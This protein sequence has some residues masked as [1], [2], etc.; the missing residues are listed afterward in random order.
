MMVLIILA[1]L[2]DSE[3]SV[4]TPRPPR[5]DDRP[6]AEAL[7]ALI[8]E[9]RRRAR[10]RRFAVCALVATSGGLLA[11]Y[12]FSGGGASRPQVH[13]G[14]PT[15]GAAVAVPG[16]AARLRPVPGLPGEDI[17]G[18][19]F[20][21]QDSTVFAAT[22][23]GV[24]KSA[25][26]GRSWRPMDLAPGA[27]R[28]DTLAIAPGDPSTLYVGTARGVFKTTDGG[29]S[30]R[31]A[32]SG[33]LGYE[34]AE[35]RQ[36]RADEGYVYALAVDPR[37]PEIAYAGTWE[38]GVFKTTNGGASWR[39]IGLSAVSPLVL[40]PRDPET[41]YAGAVG[42]AGPSGVF[43]SSDGGSSWQL[44]GLQ[45]TVVGA[46]ALDPQH[47]ET[48]Y[49]GTDGKG[50][51]KS[52]DGGASWR[53]SGLADKVHS[54]VSRLLLDPQD[55]ETV[56]AEAG[57][58]VLKTTDSGR[59]WRALPLARAAEILT[60]HPRNS[61][62]LYATSG[63]GILTSVDGGRTWRA[64]NWALNSAA[65]EA[66]S[67]DPRSPGTAYVAIDHEGVFKRSPDGSWQ[68]A[69]TGLRSLGVH[70]L[71][72]DPREPANVYAGTDGGVYKSIDGGS[73]WRRLPVPIS[74]PETASALAIDPQD[75]ETVYAITSA[76]GGWAFGGG[77]ATIYDSRVF[78]SRDGG[79]TWRA[80][81]KVQT[82]KVPAAPN[83]VPAKTV[84]GSRVAIDPLDPD[85]LY[86]GAL[87]VL[88][89]TDGGTTW[90][91]AGLARTPVGALAIDPKEPATLYVGT[92]AGLFKS[93]SAGASWQALRGPLG[94]VRV[95]ALAI[96][97]QRP[98][99]VYAGTDRG[100]F[101]TGDGGESW[102]RFSRLP[103]RTFDALAID[104]AAHIVY[105][106]AYGG[107]I[108][109]LRLSR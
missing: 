12:G 40:D 109:E 14:L 29:A 70:V 24:F 107:G 21:A 27:I 54:S 63:H 79:A 87:G 66:L 73:S 33:L 36:H 5:S 25:D 7:E 47:P 100:V 64:T 67:I 18:L 93:T 61:A 6:D 49:A 57:D 56:Y 106:G 31:A 72:V 26:G 37:D 50:V 13:S 1:S 53:A 77:M 81:G 45:G 35:E 82:L 23:H 2:E 19:L 104:S 58:G 38:K 52:T 96:N 44:V 92:D 88:K 85:T 8:K 34:T 17:N 74:Y 62:K 28:V 48:V 75:P 98:Q 90:R 84:F 55:P 101:W 65:V 22:G 83:E 78:K 80:S 94:G 51:F 105:A 15:A 97:P 95:E 108:F 43:K 102:R 16:D 4:L 39:S 9:A 46:L 42:G 68:A 32:S 91:E 99:T 69:K 30:W 10:R 76:D 86:A 20:D 103:L 59:S 60:L 3:M 89:S 11:F 41:I 71:A